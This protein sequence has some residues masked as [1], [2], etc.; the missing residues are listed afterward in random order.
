MVTTDP[1]EPPKYIEKLIA[2][3]NDG[4]KSAQL[5]ALAF[6][7]IGLFLLATAF[8]ATDEDLLLNRAITISQLGGAA[9]PVVFAFGL[10]PAVFVAAHFYTLIRYDMLAGNLRRLLVD[11]PKLVPKTEDRDRCRQLLANVEFVNALAMPK[12]S[13]ASSWMFD[14][15]VRA[16]LAVFP[17][18]VLLIVQLQSLRL[19]SEWVSWTHHA[20]V[21]ADLVLLVWFFGRLRGDDNWHFWTAPI[22]RK[23]AL[24]WMPVMVLAVD[25]A[26]LQVPR[27]AST[28][29]GKWWAAFQPVDRLLCT[30]GAWGCRHLTVAHRVIVARILDATT[31]VALR[32]GAADTDAKLLAS[33]E[34][35]SLRERSLRFADLTESE[36]FAADLTS[37]DLR[38]AVLNGIKAEKLAASGAQL[39][40]A[41]L[42]DA[43]LIGANLTQANLTDAFLIGA[44]L[45]GARLIS[46][47]LTGALLIG[48]N[49]TEANLGRANLT[50][51]YL[52]DDLV[53]ANL[54]NANLT[55]ANLT[56]A[57]VVQSQLEQACGTPAKPPP[58][59][60]PGFTFKLCPRSPQAPSAPSGPPPPPPAR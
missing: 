59:L 22:R 47:N 38:Q 58:G 10:A 12:G 51:A 21:I 46:A 37:A 2:A 26:W 31:F 57:V 30:P 23:L 20:C 52:T 50:G 6:T 48:A 60:P 32:A 39:Q 24:C 19:Q 56:D 34:A 17:M 33:F 3:I 25:L 55:G 9:V 36:L 41:A 28:T 16:L 18:T 4:A 35:A 44:N 14:W 53:R 5:G 15:T 8:S 13:R 29:D 42:G 11:L 43:F 7:A 45:T 1:F 27:P 40:H 49:L 54:L